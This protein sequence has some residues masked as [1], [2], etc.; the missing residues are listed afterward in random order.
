MLDLAEGVTTMP[1]MNFYLAL[2]AW[3]LIAA[4]LVLGVVLAT[5]GSLVLLIISVLA[6]VF[7]FSKWGCASP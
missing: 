5:K 4:V 3:L 6:F 1:P 2:S 7:A